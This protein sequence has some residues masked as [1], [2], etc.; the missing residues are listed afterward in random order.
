MISSPTCFSSSGKNACYIFNEPSCKKLHCDNIK[1]SSCEKVTFKKCSN[2]ISVI[3]HPGS[4]LKNFQKYSCDNY[5][6]HEICEHKSDHY[7]DIGC[8]L[9]SLNN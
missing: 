3:K 6:C 9:K 5:D 7:V 1:S 8:D 2:E 4:L